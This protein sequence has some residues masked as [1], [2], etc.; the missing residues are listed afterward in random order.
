MALP[1]GQ[2]MIKKYF[3]LSFLCGLVTVLALPPLSI[4]PAAVL[5]ISGLGILLGRV[6]GGR[7][8]A[9]IGWAYFFGYHLLGL[10]WISFSLFTDIG[11]YWW[12]VPFAATGL[13]AVFGLYGALIGWLVWRMGRQ[14]VLTR[15]L[16]LGMYW[17]LVE[18]VR[19]AAFT[20]FP[21][22]L[23]GMVWGDWL[24]VAQIGSV[25]G[26]HA[27][28]LLTVLA[29]SV[30]MLMIGQ[31]RR[32]QIM[33]AG[34]AVL[35]WLGLGAWGMVR[36]QTPLSAQPALTL[37]LVQPNI[38]MAA[39]HDRNRQQHVLS[40][41]LRLSQQPA[42]AGKTSIILWPETAL[43][44]D[45]V[46]DDGLRAMLHENLPSGSW[47]MTGAPYRA[48]SEGSK[49]LYYNS[50]VV[51]NPDGM[52]AGRFDKKHLVPFGE[53][54]P[55]RDVLPLDAIAAGSV[56]L[57]AGR[58]QRLINAI[59]LPPMAG[60]VCYE[61][62][63]PGAVTDP[64]NHPAWLVNVTNDGWFGHSAGPHQ[65]F[66]MARMRAIEEGV[67]MVRVANSGISG[68]IDPLG[69]IMA[70]SRLGTET[71]VMADLPQALPA[72]TLYSRW[73]EAPLYLMLG[74]GFMV[75]ALSEWRN[76]NQPLP[77]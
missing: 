74:L 24:P 11:R 53:Y 55:L 1:V 37:N 70:Q 22:N 13:P 9:L 73:R 48:Y 29:A 15:W 4:L 28:G 26:P 65:H 62:I 77:R 51:M 8:A 10:Y 20:G 19:G 39:K 47:L 71:V 59:P 41:L 42:P 49:P 69:R 46:H 76:R 3:F 60:S 21:W 58:G 25:I 33:L 50:L 40:T 36:L 34:L 66:A 7:A 68:V 52:V 16:A 38:D 63:F 61:A 57:S 30:P 67:P 54:M 14:N 43:P 44:Y 17:T 6:Q 75:L 45:L 27:L 31:S 32:R 2:K 12:L 72:P 56:D 35:P 18:Y 23:I 64:G 5:G